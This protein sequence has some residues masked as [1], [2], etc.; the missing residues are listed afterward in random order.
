MLARLLPTCSGWVFDFCD[1]FVTDVD[2]T[3]SVN[4]ST[5]YADRPSLVL[6]FLGLFRNLVS[7]RELV[8]ILGTL[9]REVRPVLT[10]SSSQDDMGGTAV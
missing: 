10:H 1:L 8:L 7:I 2:H 5:S 6:S 4:T 9:L 3:L